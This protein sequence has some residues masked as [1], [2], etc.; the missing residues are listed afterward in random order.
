MR[1]LDVRK[2]QR[3]RLLTPSNSLTWSW[4]IN[5]ET[6]G[7][8][9]LLVGADRV[10]LRYR[11]R[12]RGGEWRPMDYAVRLAWTACH[13]G[14]RRA[15][16]LCP[17]AGCGRR[18]AVLFGGAVFACRQCHRLSYRCQ[19]EA[20]EDR[21]ARRAEKL[22]ARLGW[23]PG[24]LNGNGGKPKGM[25][26]RTFEGLKATHNANAHHSLALA[27]ARLGLLTQ[28]DLS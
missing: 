5:D 14:G 3:Q 4:S 17:A 27:A 26:W 20:E 28:C 10:T 6:I 16:W 2:L 22:R 1:A 7:T 9:N 11:Q 25:H 15:W 21:A 13:F 24:I 19:R 18:A 23:E 8:I 12:E